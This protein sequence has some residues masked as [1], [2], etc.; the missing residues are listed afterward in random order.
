MQLGGAGIGPNESRIGLQAEHRA[1]T[2]AA[3]HRESKDRYERFEQ[4]VRAPLHRSLTRRRSVTSTPVRFARLSV[5]RENLFECAAHL[6]DAGSFPVGYGN[7][8]PT[9]RRSS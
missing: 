4:V 1:V 5:P 9:V 8:D 2:V 7:H 3:E 6:D